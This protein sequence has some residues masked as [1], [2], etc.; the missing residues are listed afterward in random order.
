LKKHPNSI[1]YTED[2]EIVPK[3]K[4]KALA[5]ILNP[6]GYLK[7]GERIIFVDD[8]YV[9]VITNGDT[10]LLPLLRSIDKSNKEGTILVERITD[11]GGSNLKST[12]DYTWSGTVYSGSTKR[13]QWD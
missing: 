3:V 1:S 11:F 10:E 6:D 4:E 13:V 8:I 2:G 7:I 12:A 9:K 5:K